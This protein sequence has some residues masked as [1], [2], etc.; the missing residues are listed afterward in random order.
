MIFEHSRKDT[1]PAPVVGGDA[2]DQWR[3]RIESEMRSF[4]EEGVD[5]LL[6]FHRLE[7][8]DRIDQA[9]ARPHPVGGAV[10]Q[11]GLDD[12]TLVDDRFMGGSLVYAVCSLEPVEGEQLI[13][14]FLAERP[15]FRF[16]PAPPLVDGVP[17][18]ER[19]WIRVLPGMLEGQGG[20]DGFFTAH[21]VRTA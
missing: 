19:G 17:I 18:H 11:P 13:D 3:G 14:A 7:R 6:A 16:E 10:E 9:P 5:Q 2:I 21:L 4:G 20:L 12:G 15:H 8:A 1:D